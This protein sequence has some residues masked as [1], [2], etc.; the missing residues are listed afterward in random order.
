MVAYVC[1]DGLA[2]NNDRWWKLDFL[3]KMPYIL[4]LSLLSLNTTVDPWHV[5]A[6][7]FLVPF[8]YEESHHVMS[9]F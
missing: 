1:D 2:Y 6:I 5:D 7:V 9:K 4:P 3:K 8:L